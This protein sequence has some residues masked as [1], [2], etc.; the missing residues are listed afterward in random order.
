MRKILWLDM[1]REHRQSKMRAIRQINKLCSSS[2]RKGNT[3]RGNKTIAV[4]Q[5]GSKQEW[6]AK[7][8]ARQRKLKREKR[9]LIG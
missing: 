6:E 8:R 2:R 9:I 5:R 4:Q 3:E 7:N 1:D